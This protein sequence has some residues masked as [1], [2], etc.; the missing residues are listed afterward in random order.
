MSPNIEDRWQARVDRACELQERHAPAAEI[1]RFYELVL[2]FQG[3]V[4]GSSSSVLAPQSP[5]REQ[6]DLQ[7]AVASLPELLSLT[8]RSGPPLLAAKAEALRKSTEAEWR[9][10]LRA[11]IFE[12]ES[13]LDETSRF[14]AR[15]CIQPI[16]EKLQLQIRAH[17]NYSASTCP[18]CGAAPQASVLRPESEGA[19]RWLLCS[20]CLREW[21]YRRLVCP[22]CGEED[23]DK[24]P[25]YAAEG[26]GAVR[27]EACDACHQYLKAIDLSIDGRAVPLVDEVAW[28]AL[29]L[30]AAEHGYTK[31]ASN[32]MGI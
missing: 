25:H 23:K 5:L 13:P 4:A 30:W 10:L 31:I 29:D 28:S 32:L 26:S 27:V 11:V 9:G 2:G 24:L 1:L 17:E 8:I 16:A 6:V 21:L 20:F 3:E 14:L 18:A 15:A 19:A 12:P 22:A 7:A